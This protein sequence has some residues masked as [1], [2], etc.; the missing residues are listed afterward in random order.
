M[1]LARLNR[2]DGTTRVIERRTFP[3]LSDFDYARGVNLAGGDFNHTPAGLPGEHGV[4]YR[5]TGVDYCRYIRSRGHRIVRIPFRWERVQQTLS[6]PLDPVGLGHL[7]N[8]VTAARQAGLM[9]L[10]DLHNYCRFTRLDDVE[11]MFE[12]GITKADWVDI[13]TRLA[14]EFAADP[15]VAAWGLMNEPVALPAYDPYFTPSTVFHT[16][17]AG[18]EGFTVSGTGHTLGTGSYEWGR[19][20]DGA[21]EVSKV[22]AASDNNYSSIL[23]MG[24]AGSSGA[25]VRSADWP[26]G[27]VIRVEVFI[28]ES[29]RGDWRCRPELY[30]ATFQPVPGDYHRI[31]KGSFQQIMMPVPPELVGT[32]HAGMALQFESRKNDGVTPSVIKIGQ[33]DIGTV[34]GP[35]TTWHAYSQAAVDA[36]RWLGDIR[37]IFVAGDQFGGAED[38]ATKNGPTAWITDPVGQTFYEA[39]YYCAQGYNATSFTT[40][41]AAEA[42]AVARGWADLKARV[43]AEIGDF[44]S[45]L[46][47]NN[48]KGFM[49]E[50]GWPK[51][52]AAQWNVIGDH[53]LSLLD[54]A[55]VGHTQWTAGEAWSIGQPLNLYEGQGAGPITVNPQAAT[56]EAHPSKLRPR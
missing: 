17:T 24:P 6:G 5:F 45:W 28:P 55:N 32:A 3:R 20:V 48:A 37:P 50:I 40:Y 11:V 21:V 34:A 10:L 42:D 16:F 44:T 38:W 46:A 2:S 19:G 18:I 8:A 51:T 25:P 23:R 39:H 14:T 26:S 30:S 7:K 33:V 35:R 1:S 54:A 52:D 49:G 29:T 36:I 12:Q 27:S 13:W 47:A 43:T 9:V 56:V 53:M 15:A 41:A 22:M 31:A 4:N